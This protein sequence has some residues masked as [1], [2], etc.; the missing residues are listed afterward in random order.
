MMIEFAASNKK[1]QTGK[2]VD[3]GGKWVAFFTAAFDKFALDT[4]VCQIWAKRS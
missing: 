2:T 3:S 1:G 4:M